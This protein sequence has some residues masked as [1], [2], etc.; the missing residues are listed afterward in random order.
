MENNKVRKIYIFGTLVSL[1]LCSISM[2][3]S[4]TWNPTEVIS[5]ES[6]DNSY[7]I[8][9]CTDSSSKVHA[10]WVDETNY[11]ESGNDR[12]IFYKNKPNGGGWS[13]TEVISTESTGDSNLG[14]ERCIAADD[15]NTVHVVWQDNTNYDDSGADMDIFYK[16]KPDGESW[17]TTEVV[18]TESTLESIQMSLAVESDGTVHV[19]W[20]DKTD[21]E[22]SGNDRDIFYKQKDINDGWISTEVVTTDSTGETGWSSIVVDD[23]GTTHV[24]W[25]V[26]SGHGSGIYYKQRLNDGS[27]SYKVLIS[28]ESTANSGYPSLG[29][30]GSSNLHVVWY[31]NTNYAG[32]G[33]DYDIFYKMRPYDGSW[34]STEVVSTESTGY[35]HHHPSMDV[36]SNEVAYVAWDD[37]SNYDG[38]GSDVDIFYKTRGNDGEWSMT[39]VISKGLSGDSWH[40]SITVGNNGII[41]IAWDDE[42]ETRESG[43]DVDIFYKMNVT[44]FTV[45]IDIKPGS[46]PNSINPKS[47][48]KVPV[49]I[50]TTDDFDAGDVDPDT[51]VFLD[52]T[53]VN[54]AMDDVDDDGDSDMILHFKTQEL[55][56]D[57]LIDEGGEYPYAYLTGETNDGQP[58]KG[59]DT[60]RLVG[61]LQM[62]FETLFVRIMQ[63]LERMVQIFQ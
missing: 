55:D 13:T 30:D 21:Y 14:Y 60:V 19:A 49:A 41:H 6:D 51:I 4:S 10:A 39:E 26:G 47:N 50:L 28:S 3:C 25:M 37:Y 33:G 24:A 45:A 20:T 36:G 42:T 1:I 46:Y 43:S 23:E 63:F 53:P 44:T 27:W 12:D 9:I 40:P 35:S 58:I 18:S 15:S 11:D 31:D 54:W 56:F 52:A 7:H 29:I 48:G 8:S 34:S 17:G 59:K 16:M 61:R 5:T 62:L 32:S 22:G 2:I 57:L 38:S